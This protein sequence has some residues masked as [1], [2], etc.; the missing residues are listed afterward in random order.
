MPRRARSLFPLSL[1][2]CGDHGGVVA[3]GDGGL[4][5]FR[6]W[7]QSVEVAL[8][9]ESEALGGERRAGEVAVVG[10]VVSLEAEAS[11]E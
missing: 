5:S 6:V 8:E 10:L 7:Q 11:G 9:D 4:L 2:L 1:F 3:F